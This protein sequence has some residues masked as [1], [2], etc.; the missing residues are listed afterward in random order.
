VPEHHIVDRGQYRIVRHP[1]YA[2]AIKQYFGT[3]LVF[4]TWWIVLASTIAIIAYA[5][6]ANLEDQFL[7]KNLPGYEDYRRRVKYR[8]MPGVW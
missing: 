5:M 3:A 7:A 2:S 6:K 4:L 1:I 8:L